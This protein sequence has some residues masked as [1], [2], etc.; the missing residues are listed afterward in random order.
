[1][2]AGCSTSVVIDTRECADHVVD[3]LRVVLHDCPGI[4]ALTDQGTPYMAAAT[5]LAFDELQAEHAPQKEGDPTG[6]STVERGFGSLKDDPLAPALALRQA[7]PC[8]CPRFVLPTWPSPSL[9]WSWPPPCAPT[10]PAP[11]PLVVRSRPPATPAKTPSC[12]PPP[13]PAR[14]LAPPTAARG[15]CSRTCMG[16]SSSRHRPRASS[17]STGAT[18]WRS[19][20]RPRPACEAGS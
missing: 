3:A 5:K 1:M 19:C 13:V 14:P 17:S 9:D 8:W 10:R 11:V 2:I 4:Q 12:A 7:A 18:R 20:A 15:C 6:K 16:S